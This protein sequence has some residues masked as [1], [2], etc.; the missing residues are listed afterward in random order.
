[1]NLAVDPVLERNDQPQTEQLA[2]ILTAME[3]Q[4]DSQIVAIGKKAAKLNLNVSA[5]LNFNVQPLPW[6]FEAD[7]C[8]FS[9]RKSATTTT[10]ATQLPSDPSPTHA[11]PKFTINS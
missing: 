8:Y 6:T 9:F 4:Y 11:S 7:P 10:P 3:V 5:C 1:M 2:N